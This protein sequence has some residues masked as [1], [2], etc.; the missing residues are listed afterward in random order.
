MNIN[1]AGHLHVELLRASERFA[2]FCVA[3]AVKEVLMTAFPAWNVA[4]G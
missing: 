2:S 3:V 4:C 1:D